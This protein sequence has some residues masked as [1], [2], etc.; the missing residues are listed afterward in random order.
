M[1][2]YPWLLRLLVKEL[3]LV[4]LLE[5]HDRLLP[6]A[7]LRVA[8]P[9]AL[10]L[11]AHEHRVDVDHAHLEERLDRVLY[12]DLV[13]VPGDLED[14]LVVALP[15]AVTLLGEDDRP[16]DDVFRSHCT[17]LRGSAPRAPWRRPSRRPGDRAGAGRRR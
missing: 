5:R 12:L 11:A 3:D 1:I 6:V 14:H 17:L 4:A 8:P 9:H 2:G 7:E 16:A 15:E 10:V 13:R